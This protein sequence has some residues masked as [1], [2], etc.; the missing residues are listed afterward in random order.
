MPAGGGPLAAEWRFAAG[1]RCATGPTI[2][3][4]S[5]RGFFSRSARP[6]ELS[7]RRCHRS[8]ASGRTRW[9]VG[10]IATWAGCMVPIHILLSAVLLSRARIGSTETYT[11]SHVGSKSRGQNDTLG[12]TR[13][14]TFGSPHSLL[15]ARGFLLPG[16]DA[17]EPGPTPRDR[18]SL[19][20]VTTTPVTEPAQ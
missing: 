9:L 10:G 16:S 13:V 8:D 20:Y 19:P 5:N 17:A 7:S 6:V 11:L 18:R 12:K 15:T 3:R 1:Q 4:A 2:L 14:D